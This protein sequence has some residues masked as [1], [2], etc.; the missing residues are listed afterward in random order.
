[1]ISK[2]V[3]MLIRNSHAF[4]KF[5]HRE[6][7]RQAFEWIEYQN[8]NANDHEF[9]DYEI[10]YGKKQMKQVKKITKSY[11]DFDLNKQDND[12]DWFSIKSNFIEFDFLLEK[13]RRHLS[14]LK[15]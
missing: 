2:C 7:A 3:L 6:S 9:S 14:K 8:E 11:Q 15:K 4:I 1:M 13:A 12:E 10:K 5:K